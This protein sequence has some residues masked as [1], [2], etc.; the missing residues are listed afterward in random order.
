MNRTLRTAGY[1]NV[2]KSLLRYGAVLP[3]E[4]SVNIPPAPRAE[5][6]EKAF[7]LDLERLDTDYDRQRVEVE[8]VG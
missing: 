2:V 1:R 3:A 8:C 6:L 7:N 5:H 4:G